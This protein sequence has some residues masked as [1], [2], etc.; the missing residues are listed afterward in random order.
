M[1]TPTAVE[2]EHTT[3]PIGGRWV[4]PEGSDAVSVVNPAT[5][6][7]IGT[8]LNATTALVDDAVLAAK[9]ALSQP[10]W[11]NIDPSHRA[12]LLERFADELEATAGERAMLTTVQN[13]IPISLSHMAEGIGPVFTLRYFAYLCRTTPIEEARARI[14]GAGTTIVRH[15]PVG[16]VA[17]VTPWNFP[18]N[19]AM[20]KLAPALAAGCTVVLKPAPETTLDAF[21]VAAAAERAGLPPGVFNVVTGAADIGEYLVEH[22]GVNKVAF[23]GSTRAGTAIAQT[24]GR[25]MRPAT[26]ELGGKSAAIVLD[27][28]DV[29]ELTAGLAATSLLNSGQTCYLSTRILV[30]RER[31][32]EIAEAVADAAAAL[33]IGDPTDAQT[34]LGPLV[35]AR[36]RDHVERCIALGNDS[37][38]TLLTGGGRPSGKGW[39]VSPTV[40]AG[41]HNS[42]PLARSEVFGPVLCVIPYDGVDDAVAISNDSDYG[43]GGTV[44]TG[45][46]E[47]GLAVARRI[48]TG[49]IGVNNYALDVGA[50]FGGV[51]FSGLGREL[52]PE[53][54]AAY[55]VS[56]SIFLKS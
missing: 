10:D 32:D 20:A 38:A 28:V 2:F 3:I 51:K 11:A 41:V 25:L 56:K 21:A 5:E 47:R 17:A 40:F 26:L 33:A 54:F 8:Y 39:F 12:D 48:E 45:D 50:P 49:T 52:G 18:Q 16:V 44:W 34:Q 30:P 4:R 53:G 7:T 24:C 42:D 6:E 1:P 27:D 43:L 46:N 37:D 13:G 31:H 23:T 36:Q 19:L 15:E 14:D 29:D 9:Q 55:R 22:P 35:S